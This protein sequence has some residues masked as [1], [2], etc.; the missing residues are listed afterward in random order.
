MRFFRKI[1]IYIYTHITM[2]KY[3]PLEVNA[4]LLG[5]KY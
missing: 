4:E 5:Q 1:D 2:Q 3:V